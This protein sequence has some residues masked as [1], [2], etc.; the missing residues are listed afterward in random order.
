MTYHAHPDLDPQDHQPRAL[1]SL[2][3]PSLNRYG[4]SADN[5]EMD[6]RLMLAG[7]LTAA[8]AAFVQGCLSASLEPD[9]FAPG[10]RTLRM[11]RADLTRWEL[12]RS[13]FAATRTH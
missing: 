6:S 7:S 9:N 3:A 8:D 2:L 11:T 1:D 4:H 13:A 5:F 10:G 12:I